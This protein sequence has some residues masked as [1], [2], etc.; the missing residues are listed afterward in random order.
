MPE[1]PEVESIVRQLRPALIGRTID[2][3]DLQRPDV[4]EGDIG[5]EAVVKRTVAQVARHGKAILL[6]LANTAAGVSGA[7]VDRRSITKSRRHP[8]VVRFDSPVWL[9]IR[10]GMTGQCVL[11][12]R[13]APRMP[14]T[15]AVLTFAGERWELQYRDARRFGRWRV[16]PSLAEARRAPDALALR[17]AA[18]RRITDVHRGQLRPLLM[19]QRILAGIGNIYANEILFAA[20][21]HPRQRISRLTDGQ[22]EALYRAVKSILRRGIRYGGS[23]IRDYRTPDGGSGG[24][25]NRFRVYARAGRACTRRCGARIEKLRAARDAQPGFFCPRCQPLAPPARS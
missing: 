5:I 13:G 12:P 7:G 15:H 14:H 17:R 1:L 23:T 22:R 11:A 2:G 8:Q 21:L 19:N 24:F 18:W 20:R 10:L 4:L 16:V 9:V 6:Q 3:V 25:Q